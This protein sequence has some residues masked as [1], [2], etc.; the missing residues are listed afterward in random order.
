LFEN[1][2]IRVLR[3]ECGSQHF[4]TLAGDLLDDRRV[5]QKPP[6]AKGHQV[7]E[8]SRVD[9]KLVLVLAAQDG[10]QKAVLGVVPAQCFE[11]AHVGTAGSIAS[12]A[13]G[14]IHLTT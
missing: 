1:A 14:R 13:D 9:A 12:E 4:E 5:A 3:N 11:R 10:Y 2:R 7:R 6:A 8:L